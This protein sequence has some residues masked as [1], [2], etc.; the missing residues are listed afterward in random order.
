MDFFGKVS[1]AVVGV[2]A[3]QGVVL[4]VFARGEGRES[5][6][7]QRCSCL[8]M[9]RDIWWNLIVCSAGLNIWAVGV[10]GGN[11]REVNVVVLRFLEFWEE[12]GTR[13]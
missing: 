10:M 9:H 2:E 12:A 7:S 5:C 6:Q 1:A 4:V 8:D 11:G 13:Q 3:D